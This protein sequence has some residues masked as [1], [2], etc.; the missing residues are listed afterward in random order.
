[1]QPNKRHKMTIK[2]QNK[3][4]EKWRR[5]KSMT[6]KITIHELNVQEA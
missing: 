1:M 5:E 4:Q 2:Q 6:I 3:S